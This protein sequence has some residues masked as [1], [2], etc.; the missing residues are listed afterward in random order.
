MD[1]AVADSFIDP[2]KATIFP[3]PSSISPIFSWYIPIPFFSSV[4]AMRMSKI[5][6][7]IRQAKK[8]E[9]LH[10]IVIN[11]LSVIWRRIALSITLLRSA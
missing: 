1:I 7:A 5:P 4:Y 10:G 3:S 2:E 8:I 11:L 6:S 9:S